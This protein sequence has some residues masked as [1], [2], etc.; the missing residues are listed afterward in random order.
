MLTDRVSD[1]RHPVIHRPVEPRDVRSAI[2]FVIVLACGCSIVASLSRG[3]WLDEFWSLRLGALDRP[4]WTIVDQR[5]LSDT[6]PPLANMLYRLVSLIGVETIEA[7]RLIL[8]LPALV[9]LGAGTFYFS[10]ITRSAFPAILLVLA[11]SLSG[12]TEAL[13]D[14]R[15]YAWQVAAFCLMLDYLHSLLRHEEGTPPPTAHV[16]GA[17]AIAGAIA[18]HYVAGII[19]SIVIGIAL[20]AQVRTRHSRT[21]AVLIVAAVL[22][23]AAVLVSGLIL[24]GRMRRDIDV[25]WIVTSP[26][27]GALLFVFLFMT[28]LIANPLASWFAIRDRGATQPFSS[29]LALSA[30]ATVVVLMIFNLATPILIERYL[31][32]WQLL[33]CALVALA[34]ERALAES[35][36]SFAA[37]VG[38][39]AL[40]MLI[41]T[42]NAARG[43]GWKTGRDMIAAQVRQ[44]PTTRVFAMSGWRLK[45]AHAS[46]AARRETEVIDPAYRELGDQ[47]GFGV[48]TLDLST[49]AVLPVGATCPT[50]VWVEHLSWDNVRDVAYLQRV[51]R[52]AFDH[53]VTLSVQQTG[54]GFLLTARAR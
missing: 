50:L 51:G 23:W 11:L 28:A 2:L 48:T 20:L 46:N 52:L 34:A 45:T 26:A 3:I 44:C 17:L 42:A 6:H 41:G 13:S 33:V 4:F 49:P 37:F 8:N 31:I 54:S 10:R 22:A 1:T 25:G 40:M 15:S 30:L 7:R 32:T 18:L 12:T 29:V 19:A 9:T 21:A 53:P 27:T 36:M 38:I 16:I 5:W 24:V 35:R 39:G 43:G 14:Y 47:R